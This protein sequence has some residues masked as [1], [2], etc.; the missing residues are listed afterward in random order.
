MNHHD[1]WSQGMELVG[2]AYHEAGH[3][4]I[5]LRI[6]L[7]VHSV[8]IRRK[9]GDLGGCQ[10]VDPDQAVIEEIASLLMAR[11]QERPVSPSEITPAAHEWMDKMIRSQL[12][13]PL[14][15][16]RFRGRPPQGAELVAASDDRENMQRLADVR[17]SDAERADRLREADAEVAN[18]IWDPDI[19]SAITA[20]AKA[21]PEHEFLTGEQV[22]AVYQAAISG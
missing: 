10:G 22:E 17:W 7:P 20:V 2:T 12:A 16:M 6:G 11:A 13:G 9:S 21:L 18:L 15:E 8:D 1:G 14:A 4:V 3:A 5:D 19:W